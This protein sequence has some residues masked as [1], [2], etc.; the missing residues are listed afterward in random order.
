MLLIPAFLPRTTVIAVQGWGHTA[1]PLCLLLRYLCTRLSR[2]ACSPLFCFID[3]H[4]V[5]VTHVD[6]ILG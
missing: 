6:S 1:G 5:V 2:R 3:M 4:R